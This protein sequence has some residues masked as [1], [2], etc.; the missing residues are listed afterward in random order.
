MVSNTRVC[1]RSTKRL[2][3][4]PIVRRTMKYT[5]VSFPSWMAHTLSNAPPVV[6]RRD[7]A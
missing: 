3:T 7:Q 6:V 2:V 1:R 4:P 5:A